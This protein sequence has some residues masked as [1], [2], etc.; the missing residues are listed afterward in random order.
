MNSMLGRGR[1]DYLFSEGDLG[2]GLRAHLAK[3]L[4]AVD[5]VP[6]QD[7]NAS[8][9]EQIADKIARDFSVTPLE[10]LEAD[11]RMDRSETKIDVSKYSDR[12]PFRDPGPIYTSG[13]RV[14]ITIPF[15]GDA[16]LWKLRPG[17]WRTTFPRGEVHASRGADGGTLDLVFERP[18][19]EGG[20]RI[21]Q[22]L[23]RQLDD[24]RFYI[25]NQR[26]Q[27]ANELA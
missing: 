15:R 27:I 24:I 13:I 11:K 14:V 6:E 9:D 19:D 8:T 10:I 7:F 2:N 20:E 23:E 5:A 1:D 16:G 25:G 12:N 17:T 21:K 22:D 3:A 26:Q 18:A 4:E